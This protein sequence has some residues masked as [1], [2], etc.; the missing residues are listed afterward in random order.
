PPARRTGP[1][2]ALR[3]APSSCPALWRSLRCPAAELRLDLVL[4]SGQT[5]RWPT[6]CA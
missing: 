3:D 6:A 5:F 2:M 1:P 4:S